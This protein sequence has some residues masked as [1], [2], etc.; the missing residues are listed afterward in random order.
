MANIIQNQ[1]FIIS[2]LLS[3]LGI[4]FT[5][6]FSVKR[7]HRQLA[8]TYNTIHITSPNADNKFVEKL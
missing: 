7:K 1:E 2:C 5:I 8:Y 4:I 6:Y 3:I